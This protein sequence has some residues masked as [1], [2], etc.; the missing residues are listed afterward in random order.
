[1]IPCM[2]EHVYEYLKSYYNLTY[3]SRL[4]EQHGGI[5]HQIFKGLSKP[6]HHR[7]DPEKTL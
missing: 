7:D 5:G 1:M 3:K 6:K 2:R 4:K